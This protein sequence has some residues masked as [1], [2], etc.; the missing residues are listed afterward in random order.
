MAEGKEHH[1]VGNV[2]VGEYLGL[3]LLELGVQ[4]YFT[5][6][7]DYNMLLLDEMMKVESLGLIGCCN[8]LNAGFAADGYAR[9]SRTLGVAVG[10]S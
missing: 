2:S 9:S 10:T 7:G 1:T 4:N 8:E 6:P 3:R 5:V